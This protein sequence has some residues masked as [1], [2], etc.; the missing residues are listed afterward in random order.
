MDARMGRATG[1]SELSLDLHKSNEPPQE[2]ADQGCETIVRN[3]NAVLA[4]R[5]WG[6]GSWAPDDF[7]QLG[8]EAA[9]GALVC[10]SM[11][12]KGFPPEARDFI[13]LLHI[14]M[15]R[16]KMASVPSE[17]IV[18]R[19]VHTLD[20][21]WNVIEV[22][23]SV[24]GNLLFLELLDLSHIKIFELPTLIGNLGFLKVLRVNHH[25]LVD[26][27]HSWGGESAV[28]CSCASCCSTTTT[29]LHYSPSI[30]CPF[31]TCTAAACQ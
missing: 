12:L 27:P 21:S 13:N 28:S 15:Q 19:N 16:N 25:R 8:K 29:Y 1:L 7:G 20:L 2:I 5:K 6:Q 18:F 17:L 9:G 11:K 31:N 22:V 14:D 26:P 23:S 30:F 3:W 24:L 10:T 4:A